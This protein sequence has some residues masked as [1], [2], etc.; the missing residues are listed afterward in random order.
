[1]LQPGDKFPTI[2]AQTLEDKRIVF[3]ADL[4]GTISVLVTGFAQEVQ[5]PINSWT[6]FI[7]EDYPAASY[8]EVP[9]G[10]V[11][12]AFIGRQIDN[13]MKASVP[14]ELHGKTA[15]YYGSLCSTYQQ[16]FGATD[17][18]TCYVFLLDR[19]GRIMY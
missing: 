16:Q 3:S 6:A 5:L 19:Q 12:F 17:L 2:E 4:H 9:I 18:S 14:R 8:F 13:A 1:M 15:T 7:L 11:P 10:N